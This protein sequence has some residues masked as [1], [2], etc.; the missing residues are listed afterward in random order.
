MAPLLDLRT[1]SENA[2]LVKYLVQNLTASD[3]A[4][5]TSSATSQPAPTPGLVSI[6]SPLPAETI[7]YSGEVPVNL[8]EI[9]LQQRSNDV[10][11]AGGDGADPVPLDQQDIKVASCNISSKTG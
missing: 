3:A 11:A 1:S 8:G 9:D 6:V 7:V 10:V 2:N 5:L 4:F